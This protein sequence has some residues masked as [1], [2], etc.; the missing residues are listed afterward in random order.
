MLLCIIKRGWIVFFIGLLSACGSGSTEPE[1]NNPDPITPKVVTVTG[2]SPDTVEVNVEVDFTVSG[3]DLNNKVIFELN[4]CLSPELSTNSEAELVFRCTPTITG[5][6]TAVVKNGDGK[7]LKSYSVTINEKIITPP[8]APATLKT[9]A[10]FGI[11][12]L[13]W[14]A[15]PDVTYTL[16]HR[17]IDK[18]SS[19]WLEVESGLNETSYEHSLTDSHLYEYAISAVNSAGG[20]SSKQSETTV[21]PQLRINSPSKPEGDEGVTTLFEFDITLNRAATQTVTANYKTIADTAVVGSDYLPVESGTISLPI[22]ETQISIHISVV[23]DSM[24]EED[25]YFYVSLSN[26]VNVELHNTLSKASATIL[27]DDQLPDAPSQP[28]R[29]T[30]EAKMA[31][32]LLS[33]DAQPKVSYTLYHRLISLTPLPWIVVESALTEPSYEHRLTDSHLYEYAVSAVNAGGESV[34]RSE[35]VV[36]PQLW[37]NGLS[38]DEGDEGIT[39]TFEFEAI[40]NRAA[41]QIVTAQYK[42]VA[43]SAIQ[44]DDYIGIN[45]KELSFAVGEMS[46]SIQVFVNG[47]SIVEENESFFIQMIEAQNAMLNGLTEAKAIILN[48]DVPPPPEISELSPLYVTMNTV[49]DFTVTGQFLTEM[50]RLE[51]EDCSSPVLLEGGD[52]NQQKFRC[53]PSASGQKNVQILSASNELLKAFS[54]TVEPDVD[55]VAEGAI[56]NPSEGEELEGDI[57][58]AANVSDIDGLK[59]VSLLFSTSNKPLILCNVAMGSVCSK[60]SDSWLKTINPFEYSANGGSLAMELWVLDTYDKNI[61]VDTVTFQWQ[62]APKNY[63]LPLND[64]GVTRF[65]NAESAVIPNEEPNDYPRQDASFGRDVTHNDNSDGHAGFSF[66]KLDNLGN[67]LQASASEWSCIRDNVTG[68]IWESKTGDGGLHDK[69]E[70]F[71]WYTSDESLPIDYRRYEN[72]RDNC[73]GYMAGVQQSYCNTEAYTSRVNSAE[74]CGSNQWRL[75]TRRELISLLNSERIAPAIDPDWF[76]NTVHD[77]YWSSSPSTKYAPFA[78]GVDFNEGIIDGVDGKTAKAV[79]LVVK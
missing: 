51:I 60:T 76:P 65:F 46:S 55:T 18:P 79:R 32:N 15:Q 44:D 50:I 56:T 73:N 54:L 30:T 7:I 66:T 25:E 70:R 31:I 2:F 37:V 64:T 10:K 57:N 23:G 75:P 6:Q 9:E 35:T 21:I 14:S 45:N 36:I 67:E 17:L 48:D 1:S 24:I 78:W 71:S 74:L 39:T 52:E 4:G 22:G 41:M 61:L 12:L 62:P 8:V 53:T 63:S 72:V 34:K 59:K 13:S 11:N 77:F 43:D 69:N 29:L 19:T 3:K 20:E 16:Y 28:T 49:I 58:I 38:K 47:D 68:L 33:W 27:N 40:L 42:T 5:T 26:A